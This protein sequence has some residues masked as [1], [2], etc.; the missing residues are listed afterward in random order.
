MI[1]PRTGEGHRRTQ[2]S[3]GNG[4]GTG[5]WD[6]RVPDAEMDYWVPDHELKDTD[7]LVAFRITPQ[8]GVEAIEASAQWRVSRRPPRG[9]WLGRPP[10]RARDVPGQVLPGRRGPRHRWPVHRPLPRPRP[11]GGSTASG[12]RSSRRRAADANMSFTG[13]PGTGKTTAVQRMAETLHKLGYIAR[14]TSSR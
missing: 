12:A 5:R 6:A 4:K 2:E 1:G 9:A 14:G 8:P 11:S 3:N 13:N 10:D 7:V